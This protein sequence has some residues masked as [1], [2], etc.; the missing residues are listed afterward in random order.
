MNPPVL[1]DL[2]CLVFGQ[3]SAM[4]RTLE[5]ILN[6]FGWAVTSTMS[7]QTAHVR[8]LRVLPTVLIADSQRDDLSASAL[9]RNT[10]HVGWQGRAIVISDRPDLITPETAAGLGVERILPKP[11]K[12]AGLKRALELRDEVALRASNG[13]T[14]T[15][16]FA[17]NSIPLTAQRFPELPKAPN[18]MGAQLCVGLLHPR[19]RHLQ[20][21][22]RQENRKH[23][24]MDRGT[25][26][27]GRNF[28]LAICNYGSIKS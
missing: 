26:G 9:S 6:G 1:S 27:H 23:R 28:R 21:G 10:R 11:F 20:T 13:Q 16:N 18:V 12:L 14:R 8:V 24:G 3:N 17:G 2:T 25:Y 7:L 5:H 22:L 4:R 15:R 19:L